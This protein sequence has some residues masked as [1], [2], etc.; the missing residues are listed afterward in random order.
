MVWDACRARVL[1]TIC[2]ESVVKL[3]YSDNLGA[4][5]SAPRR[6]SPAVGEH[7][8][9][10]ISSD[11]AGGGIAVAWFTNRFDRIFHNRQDVELVTLNPATGAVVRSQ[12]LTSPSNE[13]EADPLLGGVF[14]GDY[15]E[16]FAHRGTAWVHYNANYTR[17]RL[18]GEGFPIA[19]QDNY[20]TITSL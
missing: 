4:S 8:F 2:E 16:V 1:D 7:Y 12:R 15:I 3:S 9:P 19:Q 14:I 17:L 20:L 10:T 5:W 6:I 13:P 18:L 11:H